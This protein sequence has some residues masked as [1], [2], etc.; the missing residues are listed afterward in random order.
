MYLI[1]G[2]MQRARI[3]ISLKKIQYGKEIGGWGPHRKQWMCLL[4]T[5]SKYTGN[6]LKH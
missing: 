2:V 3:T 5:Q 1:K 4:L 6:Q